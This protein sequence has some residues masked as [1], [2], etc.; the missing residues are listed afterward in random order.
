M[1]SEARIW[2]LENVHSDHLCHWFGNLLIVEA[3]Y[4]NEI[5]GA[6]IEDGLR[7]DTDFEVI[8]YQ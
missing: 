3:V 8:G 7:P 2:I 4:A 1:S 5:V 6:M